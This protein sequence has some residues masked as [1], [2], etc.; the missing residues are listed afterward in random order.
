LQDASGV[1]AGGAGGVARDDVERVALVPS[2]TERRRE[3]IVYARQCVMAGR[4]CAEAEGGYYHGQ[5]IEVRDGAVYREGTDE[6]ID[7]LVVVEDTE[8]A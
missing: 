4:R 7:D 1:E 3:M 2:G 6:M 5:L 8:D